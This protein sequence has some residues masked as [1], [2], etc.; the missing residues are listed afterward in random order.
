[1]RWL[2]NRGSDAWYGFSRWALPILLRLLGRLEFQH[3]E[4][5]PL[6]GPVLIVANHVNLIDPILV[7][8][9]APRR[10]RPMAKRELFETPLV[11]WLVWLYGAFP[12]RRYS[13][14]LGA[15]RVGRNHLRAGRAVLVHPEGTRSRTAEMQPGLPGSAMLAL[16]GGANIVP[17]A[18]TGT[19][20]ITGP[21]SILRAL[22][23]RRRTSIR[24]VFGEPFTLADGEPSSD[25]AEAATDLMMRRVA[26]LLPEQYRGA[27]G[28]G[29][30]GTLVV[31]RQR[32][33]RGR[34]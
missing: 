30:E 11:G 15:L 6:D 9:A 1:M 20:A 26:A 29:S 19:E 10:L 21:R 22:L 16:L 18:V 24:V 27:Y 7:C 31:A 28:A 5:V 12:V 13:A 3:T 33:G 17:C 2:W 8:A 23:G 25:R 14:D 32:N 4:R 34:A